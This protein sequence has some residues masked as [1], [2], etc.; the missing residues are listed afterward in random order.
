MMKRLCLLILLFISVTLFSHTAVPPATGDG[1]EENP[2]QIES[3]E[4]LYWLS[5]NPEVWD[6]H[7]I[8]TDTIHASSTSSWNDNKGW[9]PIGND[10]IPFTG[11]YDGKGFLIDS[12]FINRQIIYQ[13]L[14]GYVNGA[15]IQNLGLEDIS[16]QGYHKM[17]GFVGLCTGHSRIENC[18]STGT[19]SGSGVVGGIVG[20]LQ[21]SYIFQ[22][23]SSADIE[24]TVE[25][26]GIAGSVGIYSV[27]E[28]CYSAGNIYASTQSAGGL[29]GNMH[30]KS[31]IANSYSRSSV[32]AKSFK[33]GG[34]VGTS[35]SSIILNSYSTGYVSPVT[36][37]GGLTAWGFERDIINCFWNIETSGMSTSSAGTGITTEEMRDFH[38]FIENCWDFTGYGVEG[39]WNIGNGRNDGFPYLTWTY[40]QDPNI[41]I[42]VLPT[43]RIDSITNITVHNA[44]VHAMI[45]NKG[46][47]VAY[48]HGICWNTTGNPTIHDNKTEEGII[49]SA[50][51]FSSVIDSIHLNVTYY[52]R[53][54]ATSEFGTAYSPEDTLLTYT[55]PEGA[56]TE[57]NPYQIESWA[58]LLWMTLNSSYYLGQYF[59]QTSDIDASE[60][61]LLDNG[62]GWIPVETIDHCF[63]DG[64][65]HK[66]EGLYIKRPEENNIGLFGNPLH[67]EIINLGMT[68][69]N[70]V[71]MDRVGSIAGD[72]H[73]SY[74]TGCYSSGTV[75]GN[76]QVGGL[77][78]SASTIFI[79]PYE[80]W[81]SIIR[82]SYSTCDVTGNKIVGGLTGINRF[83]QIDRCYSS[84]S[85]SGNF[86]TGGLVGYNYYGETVH[87]FWDNKNSGQT[88][89]AGGIGK[90]PSE[91]KK[92]ETFVVEYWDF[93]ELGFEGIWNI[94]SERNDGYPYLAWEYPDDG[95][96]QN[97]LPTV[98]TLSVD[99]IQFD[100][101]CIHYS[102]PNIGN[103]RGNQY[104]VCWDTTGKPTIHESKIEEGEVPHAGEFYTNITGLNINTK[105]YV[106]PYV[107]NTIG[108]TYGDEMTFTTIAG[109][110]TEDDPYQIHTLENL[111]WLMNSD[112]HW[113]RHYI[114]TSNIDASETA[115]WDGGKGWFPIGYFPTY[116]TG[117]YDGNNYIIDGL[118]INRP[119]DDFEGLFGG[120]NNAVIKN[121]GLVNVNI[122]GR[123]QTGGLVGRSILSNIQ[124][125]YTTGFVNG[126]GNSIGG[127]AGYSEGSM[128]YNSFSQCIVNGKKRVGG[129]LGH[130]NKNTIVKDSYS[131]EAVIG[132]DNVGG[133]IGRTGTDSRIYNC[134][135]IS[136]VSGDSLIGGFIG[137]LNNSSV[138]NC[139]C[140]GEISGKNIVGGFIG[141]HGASS[142]LSKCL[143][144]GLVSGIE[145]VGGLIGKSD[146]SNVSDSFWDC[147]T[148]RINISA[149]GSGKGT[150]LLMKIATYQNAGWNFKSPDS[151]GIWNMGNN[152]NDGYPYLNWEYPDDP[153][154]VGIADPIIP[155]SYSISAN[156][157]NPFN[158]VTNIQFSLPEPAQITLNIYDI[159]G[160]LVEQLVNRHTPA[161]NHMITWNATEYSSGIYFA[162]M[163]T[164][165][166]MQT[167]KMVLM[168]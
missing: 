24:G 88:T 29:V 47:P 147:T 84:G 127:L 67:S 107:T 114:Q 68:N 87:S 92:I 158:P 156:Y 7:F 119:E 122:T 151:T 94:Q 38:T 79:I 146:N 49:A 80:L 61:I 106:R 135:S 159:T 43:V 14:F 126:S 103:P 32:I 95:G 50:G 83:S 112:D 96:P 157:P 41:D 130:I 36:I 57:E 102:I 89:S 51:P 45:H 78:G 72:L 137:E 111:R 141:L 161:G 77:T 64:N 54:Y 17:G 153:P 132:I 121:L 59:I 136:H 109:S 97:V 81:T 44:I 148:S 149:G 25:I 75:N 154:Y 28:Q 27:I 31:S 162:R 73:D 133:L 108:T 23:W 42:T 65:G 13:G 1:S 168:K 16:Y 4:N 145:T 5:Q 66:I 39:I 82:N 105:V 139:Y 85:V 101:A 52:I 116:F 118:F 37:S 128:V 99:S 163:Q 165:D 10:T 58:N 166:F 134:M 100:G 160:R 46:N 98:F 150:R 40:P 55:K 20:D 115:N 70:I 124:N 142:H 117:V 30:R 60:S 15:L 120:I 26:A 3:L 90:S 2:Y 129:L 93:K 9:M 48:E 110:G 125:C 76:Q 62:K 19:I 143:S 113:D 91:L 140:R 8:Q 131:S 12:L 35:E 6:R 71:G 11:S 33:A 53:A 167:K 138:Q 56:G 164:G 34:L 74:V 22:C 152:R 144:T 104:G 155:K 18:Y 63:Y 123:D 86:C 69:V 21:Q